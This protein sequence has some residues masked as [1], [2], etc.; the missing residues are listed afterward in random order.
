VFFWTQE[1]SLEGWAKS[2]WPWDQFLHFVFE[3]A[4]AIGLAKGIARL[5]APAD[6]PWN[7]VPDNAVAP[8]G[9]RSRIG[10]WLAPFDE[11]PI[12]FAV[13]GVVYAKI[14]AGGMPLGCAGWPLLFF[15][16][17]LCVLYL[18]GLLLLLVGAA[19]RRLRPSSSAGHLLVAGVTGALVMVGPTAAPVAGYVLGRAVTLL[20]G[21]SGWSLAPQYGIMLGA[22]GEIMLGAVRW[23][24][25][26]FGVKGAMSSWW[27]S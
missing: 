3:G 20:P 9:W 6:W 2:G 1:P 14:L 7:S 19:T 26:P 11:G 4:L 10:R 8:A 13:V 27:R 18:S 12:M 5:F 22:A 23:S 25:T 16:W 17:G 24:P 21:A 15:A